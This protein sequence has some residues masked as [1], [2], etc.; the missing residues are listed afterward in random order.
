MS[1]PASPLR[2][3]P[4]AATFVGWDFH[5]LKFRAFSR[6]TMDGQDEQDKDPMNEKTYSFSGDGGEP[7]TR[8]LY[9]TVPTYT[10]RQ[11]SRL[12]SSSTRKALKSTTCSI[13]APIPMDN[14]PY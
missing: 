11:H 9:D 13:V 2:L 12:V 8:R 1:L 7:V 6:R 5:P 4:T 3:L 10:I 14:S